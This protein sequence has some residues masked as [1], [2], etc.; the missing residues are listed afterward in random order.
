MRIDSLNSIIKLKEWRKEEISIQVKKIQK[1]IEQHE[2][3]IRELEDEFEKNLA[4]FR[5]NTLNKVVTAEALRIQ[6]DF[7]EH[8]TRKVKEQKDALMSRI[9]ELKETRSRLTDAHKEE[10]LVKKLKTKHADRT[11]KNIRIKEQKVIDDI[12][13]KRYRR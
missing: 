5:R 8:L 6:H 10:K 4:E 12:S 9:E 3:S 7:I 2:Q 11:I 1:L 13:I